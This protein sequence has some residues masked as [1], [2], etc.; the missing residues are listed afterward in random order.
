MKISD[1]LPCFTTA[2]CLGCCGNLLPF[3]LFLHVVHRCVISLYGTFFKRV[4]CIIVLVLFI[5]VV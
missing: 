3:L 4:V 2:V 5:Q 1:S